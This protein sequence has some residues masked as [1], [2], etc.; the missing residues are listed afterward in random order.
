MLGTRVFRVFVSSTFRDMRAERDALQERVFPKLR[1]RC[2]AKGYGFQPVDLRWGIGEEASAGQRTVRICLSEVARCQQMSPRPNFVV[3]LGDRYGWRPLPE[4]I[5]GEEFV[6]LQALLS[7]ADRLAAE[8]AYY[9]DD[10]A[11]PRPEYVLRARGEAEYDADAL[12]EALADAARRAGLSDAEL[13]KYIVSATEQEILKGA[14]EVPD[15]GEHVFCFLR[16]LTGL[17]DQVPPVPGSAPAADYRDFNPDGT[18]DDEAAVLLTDLKSR[19]RARLAGNAFGY[20]AEWAGD[21]PS[22]GHIDELCADMLS[23]LTRVID[24]EIDRLGA[25]SHLEQER[26]AHRAFADEYSADFIGR[27]RYL[28]AIASYLDSGDDHPLCLLGAGGLGKSALMAR[29]A[30]AAA[31]QHPDAIVVARF[32]GV[33]PASSDLRSLLQDLYSEIGDAYGSAEP[34]PSTL[35]DLQRELLTRFQLATT[36]KP[37]IVFLDSL[38]QLPGGG[39]LSWLPS[40][41]PGNV[42]VVTA[43]RPGPLL[44]TLVSR[45]PARLVVELEKM[46]PGEGSDLLDTWLGRNG[47]T[48]TDRQRDEIL[49]RFAVCGSPLYLRLAFEEAR[50]W[51]SSFEDV[52]LGADECAIIGDLYDR[53]ETEHGA[54]LVAHALGFLACAYDRQGL[55]EE[56]LLD[57]LASDEETWAEFTAGARW[58]MFVRQLPAVV[59]SRLYFDLAPYLSP[60]ASEGASLLSYFHRELSDVARTRYVDGRAPHMHGVLADVLRRL[61][62]G[63]AAGA[64]EWQG[65]T[66]A[67][68]ELPYHL[69]QAERWDDLFA[70]LTDFT[71]LEAKAKR[72]AVTTSV[73]PESAAVYNGVLELIADYD[74]AIAAF[75]AAT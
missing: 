69:T 16:D 33:T 11:D 63:K 53:L 26:A 4:V 22:T 48:L 10:N 14:F 6:T 51:P 57:A 47:R 35:Q 49:G 65:S 43:S 40:D 38:D 2:A 17:P 34:V 7:P 25:Y 44:D 67:L 54:E 58:G 12:R 23:S 27:A 68:A 32:I 21:E 31:E 1:A 46:P 50:L 9:R 28:G 73:G 13:A 36:D 59:W 55:T 24:A 72:V 56:E 61:A 29:G 71:Y 52:R 42:R 39:T 8:A 18:P 37:L 74:R 15:A 3:L 30:T 75:P 19:L 5:E 41:L 20:Q 62:R 64:R 60:R 70:V 66:H 45:L